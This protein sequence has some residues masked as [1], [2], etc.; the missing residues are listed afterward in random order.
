MG[1]IC[2][3]FCF[4]LFLTPDCGRAKM[5]TSSSSATKKKKTENDFN[6]EKAVED[7]EGD[8]MMCPVKTFES[9]M[10]DAK[11]VEEW[12]RKFHV[13]TMIVA[14]LARKTPGGDSSVKTTMSVALRDATVKTREAYANLLQCFEPTIEQPAGT[15]QAQA[16]APVAVPAAAPDTASV[17]VEE[18]MAAT[19]NAKRARHAQAHVHEEMVD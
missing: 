17:S 10:G 15:V 8:D 18:A 16:P 14:E 2:F 5:Q 6:L 19:T 3:C 9:V 11:T 7:Y 12:L 4:C 1:V 13:A